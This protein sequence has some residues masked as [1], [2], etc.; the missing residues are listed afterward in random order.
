LQASCWMAGM[1]DVASSATSRPQVETD[2]IAPPTQ[3]LLQLL[4]RAEVGD[5]PRVKAATASSTGRRDPA[6][7]VGTSLNG[8]DWP[9]PAEPPFCDTPRCTRLMTCYLRNCSIV[10]T[11]KLRP[12]SSLPREIACSRGAG[13]SSSCSEIR[14]QSLDPCDH[15]CVPELKVEQR[16]S[17]WLT[18]DGAARAHL[19]Y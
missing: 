8:I 3:E 11:S 9:E 19:T 4:R 7:A 15:V 14:Q 13:I 12:Q 10:S 6:K 18:K 17:Y 5:A 16:A 2:V 1:R